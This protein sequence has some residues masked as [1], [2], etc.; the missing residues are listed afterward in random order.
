VI[1]V[2][3]TGLSQQLD[4]E[5]LRQVVRVPTRRPPPRSSSAFEGHRAVSGAM[6]CSLLWLP[7]AP[8][9]RCP[10][11]PC[12]RGLEDLEAL[13]TLNSRLQAD[14]GVALAVRLG[15][16]TGPVVV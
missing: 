6:A 7:R 14:H 10:A 3:S 15:L 5:D 2:D 13:G 11:A 12:I 4:P 1:W 8:M 9:G 16:H